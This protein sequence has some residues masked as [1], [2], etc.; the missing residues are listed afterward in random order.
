[1]SYSKI[2]ATAATK[3]KLRTPES[4]SPFSGMCTTCLDGCIGY[5]EIGK[6]A[7]RGREYIYPQPFGKITSGSQKDYPVDFSHFN[8]IGRVVGAEGISADPDIA[9]FPNVNIETSISNSNGEIKLRVPFFTTGLGSTDVA[10]E[11]WEGVAI[12]CAIS[13][14]MVGIGEN[15][16]GVDPLAEIKNGRIIKS[17]E[18]ERRIKLF[19]QWRQNNEGAVIVQE[20]VEDNR[21]G[22]LEYVIEKLGIEFVELKW[23][24]GAKSIGG[25]I[26][27]SSLERATELKKRGYIVYPDP[28]D[29]IVQEEFNKGGIKEFERHSR[30]G[31]VNKEMFLKRVE[32]LR[33]KGAKYISLKT[34]AYRPLDLARALSYASEAKVDLLIIDGAGGGTGMSPWRMMN[35]WGIPTVYL[36]CLTY[37]YCEI[38]AKRGKH[39]PTIAIAGGFTVEDLIFKGLA[40][41]APYVKLIA[42]GRAPI[43]AAMVGK[44]IG[45]LI[46]SGKVPAEYKEYGDTIEQIFVG[47]AELKKRFGKDFEKIP[48]SAI[49]LYTYFSRLATGLKQFM[50]GARKFALK[51]IDRSD[52]VAL[53]KEA[54]EISGIPYVMDVDKEEALKLLNS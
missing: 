26:K 30:L 29:L 23:G 34:G 3:T 37:K 14:T 22:V 13:G 5:C 4:Y 44:T 31:M 36:E 6:S 35:E 12:G 16:C 43:T 50:A 46:K 42:M 38:L 10:R 32:E 52:L 8:I 18:M 15:V 9:T 2:N 27:L 7:I 19:Q 49:G 24:Q 54:S 53:T 11:N 47:S 25:E 17:P 20:N 51:Y 40:L 21:L 28:D 48:P 39:I 33:N 1:M 45:N 41:A